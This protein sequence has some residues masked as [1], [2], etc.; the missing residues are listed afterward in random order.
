MA[1]KPQPGRGTGE[2]PPLRR[3]IAPVGAWNISEFCVLE[4]K[5]IISENALAVVQTVDLYAL[6]GRP[7]GLTAETRNKLRQQYSAALKALDLNDE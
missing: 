3:R 2:S 5:G 6:L 7:G 4:V 1:I